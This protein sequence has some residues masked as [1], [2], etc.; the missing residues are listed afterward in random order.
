MA[1]CSLKI[2]SLLR[3]VRCI[4]LTSKKRAQ[5]PLI[6]PFFEQPGP[7]VREIIKKHILILKL[8]SK[9]LRGG[10]GRLCH[11]LTAEQKSFGWGKESLNRTCLFPMIP[12]SATNTWKLFSVFNLMSC[13]YAIWMEIISQ[14]WYGVNPFLVTPIKD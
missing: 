7:L 4:F 2:L 3:Y 14:I 10:N 9:F 12:T 6:H 11:S 8:T 5:S 13:H 1:Q